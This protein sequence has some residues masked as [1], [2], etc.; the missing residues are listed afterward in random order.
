MFNAVWGMVV[1]DTA[2]PWR[3]AAIV[4]FTP[5]PASEAGAR[6][7][8][9][10]SVFDPYELRSLHSLSIDDVGSVRPAEDAQAV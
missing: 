8:S 6:T 3:H 5:A 4:L 2:L 10:S 7:E 9:I 1:A